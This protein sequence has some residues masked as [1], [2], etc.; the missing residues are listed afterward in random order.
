MREHVSPVA[1]SVNRSNNHVT[2]KDVA[3]SSV[4][5]NAMK[6]LY[7]YGTIVMILEM[8]T[9]RRK[10]RAM[11]TRVRSFLNDFLI[12]DFLT[13]SLFVHPGIHCSLLPYYIL[14]SR[15]LKMRFS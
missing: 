2:P 15:L 4:I 12:I 3:T 5:Y 8:L 13:V 9:L 7:S 11:M 1:Q 14:L 6:T 10:Q